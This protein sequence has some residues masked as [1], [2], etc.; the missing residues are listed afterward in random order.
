[1]SEDTDFYDIEKLKDIGK[2]PLEYL[3][4]KGM[5]PY[6]KRIEIDLVGL[7]IGIFR[8]ENAYHLLDS[9]PNLKMLHGID[10]YLPHKYY[11]AIRTQEDMSKYK[12]I[13]EKN[14]T[15]FS[16]RYKL[17]NKS[18]EQAVSDFDDESLDFI[19]IDSEPTL[20]A[21][22]RQLELYY[23]KLKKQ[24]HMFIHDVNLNDVLTATN[25][26]RDVNRIRIPMHVSKNNTNFWVKT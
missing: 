10:N 13:A 15:S 4:S 9:L 19:L 7:E 17:T 25:V 8:G 11:N 12:A 20:N 21:V 6:L 22:K 5:I 3:P 18:F 23:P 1:M 14:L 26:Y 2:W 16:E 24:G